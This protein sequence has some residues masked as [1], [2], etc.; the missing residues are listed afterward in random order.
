MLDRRMTVA[1]H[2]H[3]GDRTGRPLDFEECNQDRNFTMCAQ[4]RPNDELLVQKILGVSLCYV[5]M[6]IAIFKP[7]TPLKLT[8]LYL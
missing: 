7:I 1:N 4:N 6:R 8:M 2:G 3:D 5:A